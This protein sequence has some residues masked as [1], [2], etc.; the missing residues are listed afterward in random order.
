[1]QKTIL[2]NPDMNALKI[3]S[4]NYRNLYLQCGNCEEAEFVNCTFSDVEFEGVWIN[5]ALFR[6]CQFG[7]TLF[8]EVQAYAAKFYESKFLKVK[9]NGCNLANADFSNSSFNEVVFAGDNIGSATDISG[10]CFEGVDLKNVKFVN[11]EYNME[12]SFPKGFD[13]RNEKGLKLIE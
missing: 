4:E 10:A 2:N 9:F 1:M 12:T 3:N 8:Y 11:A 7:D 6:S 5:E 13:P